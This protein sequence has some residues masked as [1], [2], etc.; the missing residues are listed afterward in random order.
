VWEMNRRI[1]VS[2]HHDMERKP[3]ACITG[4]PLLPIIFFSRVSSKDVTGTPFALLHLLPQTTNLY[5]FYLF[6]FILLNF[7][8]ELIFDLVILVVPTLNSREV[9]RMY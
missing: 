7:K 4:S 5:L 2:E 3:L 8:K 1:L 9:R 6:Y